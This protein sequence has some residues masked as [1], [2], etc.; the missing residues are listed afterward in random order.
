MGYGSNCVNERGFSIKK[1]IKVRCNTCK[2]IHI[3]YKDNF[4]DYPW[5]NESDNGYRIEHSYCADDNCDYCGAYIKC[6]IHVS[7]YNGFIEGK[8]R[9]E[10]KGCENLEPFYEYIEYDNY[11]EY[12]SNPEIIQVIQH[13]YSKSGPLLKIEVDNGNAKVCGKYLKDKVYPSIKIPANRQLVDILIDETGTISFEENKWKLSVLIQGNLHKYTMKLL[14]KVAE[15]VVVRNC[16]NDQDI[17]KK[18]LDLA[19]KGISKKET[20]N[21]YRAIGT[22]LHSTELY[23]PH[24]YN[25]SDTQRDII[26]V[27]NKGHVVN[28]MDSNTVAG[29]QAGLQVKVSS[30]GVSY[31]QRAMIKG[32]YEV[33]VVYFAIENDFDVIVNNLHKKAMSGEIDPIE[34]GVD[35]IDAQAVDKLSYDMVCESYP[36]LMGLFSG[37]ISTDDF[38][39]E[40]YGS[41]PLQN[42]ILATILEERS[43]KIL[44]VG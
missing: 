42:A 40:A 19:R 21:R 27:D 14:G 33:P 37:K 28:T 24:K 9:I 34:I 32:Q 4:I 18:W 1:N 6:C 41:L 26:W 2:N 8:E 39:K 17:N 38:V 20:A 30:N 13:K 22:G 29:N 12:V 11:G 15:A 5:S 3:F 7:E 10:C 35:L 23:F 44:I 31:V 36:L 25:P 43:S 16:C